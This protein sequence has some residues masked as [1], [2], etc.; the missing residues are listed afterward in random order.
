MARSGSLG[1]VCLILAAISTFA[2]IVVRTDHSQA[3][4]AAQFADVEASRGPEVIAAA[5]F[6]LG[7][8]LFVPAG[9]GIAR[10][11]EGR[12]GKLTYVGAIMLTVG[13]IWFATGRAM[14]AHLLYSATKPGIPR[15]QA[16]ESLVHITSSV[17]FAIFLPF[18]LSFITAP[19]VLGLGFWKMGLA[20]VWIVPAWVVS[21]GSFL[22]VEGS[23][24]GEFV[25]FGLM[26]LV[27][28]WMGLVLIRAAQPNAGSVRG[29]AALPHGTTQL[30]TS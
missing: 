7:A 3:D 29:S 9:I 24:I 25:G 27:L 17:S 21:L 10:I 13:G 12:G 8:I 23:D 14:T 19:I 30:H 5:L 1:G 18:L 20:P 15:D 16:V 26:T 22:V 28:S 6:V 11:A 2:A 4:M